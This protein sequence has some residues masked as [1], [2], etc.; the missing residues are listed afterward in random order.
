MSEI[1]VSKGAKFLHAGVFIGLDHEIVEIPLMI[2]ILY[3]FGKISKIAY[4]RTTVGIVG[5]LFLLKMGI[6]LLLRD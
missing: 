6:G 2:L 4:I 1:S 5:G 3:Y